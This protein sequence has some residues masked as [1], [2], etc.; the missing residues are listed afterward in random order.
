MGKFKGK[1]WEIL[2]RKNGMYASI[3][4]EIICSFGTSCWGLPKK[5]NHYDCVKNQRETPFDKEV[6]SCEIKDAWRDSFRQRSH[7]LW[8]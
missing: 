2:K 5:N 1:E 7:F 4:K 8:S 6:I 3:S